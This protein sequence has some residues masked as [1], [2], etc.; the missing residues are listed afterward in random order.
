MCWLRSWV[1]PGFEASCPQHSRPRPRLRGAA[2][3]SPLPRLRHAPRAQLRQLVEAVAESLEAHRK[4]DALFRGLKDDKGRGR[5]GPQLLDQILIH[6][7]LGHA[8]GRKA[9]HETGP[10]DVHGID[11]E[12]ES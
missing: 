11:L 6:D 12:A 10:S 1:E 2:A 3:A 7:H 8:A 4:S 5:P 9:T